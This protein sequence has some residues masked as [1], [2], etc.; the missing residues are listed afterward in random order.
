MNSPL[1]FINVR[2]FAREGRFYT[3]RANWQRL[4]LYLEPFPEVELV[5]VA[6][7]EADDSWLPL[8]ASVRC[9]CLFREP[10][11]PRSKG[12]MIRDILSI[13]WQSLG[14]A[15]RAS[16][17][18]LLV[19]GPPLFH[20]GFLAA[21]L[22]LRP[23]CAIFIGSVSNSYFYQRGKGRFPGAGNLCKGL[24]SA[25]M[26]RLLIA[27]SQL[28]MS[29]GGIL[30]E[31]V[32]HKGIRFSTST[33]T[34]EEF[35]FREDTCLNERV[36]WVYSGVLNREKGVDTLLQ[37]LREVRREDPRHCAVLMGRRDPAFDIDSVLAELGLEGCV[38]LTGELGRDQVLRVLREGD[39]FVFLSL[40]E[41]MPKAPLEAMAQGLPV[42]VTPTGA[43][44]YVKDGESGMVVPTGEVHRVAAA[45]RLL[46]SDG[47]LRRRMIQGGYRT[48][49]EHTYLHQVQKVHQ[50]LCARL[51]GGADDSRREWIADGL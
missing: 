43:E 14:R 29:A 13:A 21:L 48:A 36:V 45:V 31:K 2:L 10:A 30:P 39:L 4:K 3:D 1:Y 37:A 17:I 20:A 28:L 32:M 19:S 5:A 7:S 50:V 11:G 40:H 49:T 46:C 44:F 23:V 42:I 8:P 24:A 6:A 47:E 16:F 12:V 26:E 41:G 38:Q 22:T 51:A 15:R 18:G 27:R 34:R 25:L 9:S 35:S 33:L